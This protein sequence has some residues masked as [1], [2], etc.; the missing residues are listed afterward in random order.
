MI[1][2]VVFNPI[3]EYIK[4]L[5]EKQGYQLST[6]TSAMFVNTTP[7]ADDFNVMSRNTKEHQKLVTD[8]EKKLQSMGLVIKAPKC[9]SLSIQS[10]KTTNIHFY[11]NERT[12]IVTPISTV[13]EKP[14]KFLGSEVQKDNSPHAMFA[15]LSQKLKSKLE[16]I[17]KCSLRGEY[18]ANIYVRYALP[19]LRYFMSVHHIH[20]THEEQLDSLARKYLKKWYN[21]QK[22]GVTDISIFHPYLLGIKAPSQIYKEAHTST[23]AM[24]RL[25]GDEIVNQAIDSRLE[26]ESM[27]VK[28]SSTI[29]QADCIF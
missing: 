4:S 2:L 5:K 16:N 28:K 9:C 27:W 11:L 21:I 1:F 18:K 25:K 14:M 23:Y 8:V 3:I 10:G 29:V 15:V 12:N 22:N 26:R 6:K 20:K 24:M 13:I 7:F 17:D 19:S